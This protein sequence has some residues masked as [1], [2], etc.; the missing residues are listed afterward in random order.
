MLSK[1]LCWVHVTLSWSYYYTL[2]KKT[3]LS[4][5]HK[6][7]L[8]NANHDSAQFT[9]SSRKCWKQRQQRACFVAFIEVTPTTKVSSVQRQVL[10]RSLRAQSALDVFN[11]MTSHNCR[12]RERATLHSPCDGNNVLFA[13]FTH[14]GQNL[15][16]SK[17]RGSK[18][19]TMSMILAWR[20]NV[21]FFFC[22]KKFLAENFGAA[23]NF[24]NTLSWYCTTEHFSPRKISREILSAGGELLNMK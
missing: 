20:N 14:K 11:I 15:S 3:K 8:V 7:S 2:E 4:V 10:W 23:E 9:S 18:I 22:G 1:L 13:V 24:S 17:I 6:A 12:A 16:R 19:F 5:R 21:I